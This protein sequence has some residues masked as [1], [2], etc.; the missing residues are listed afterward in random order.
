MK[1]SI[2]KCAVTWIVALVMGVTTA[3]AQNA[4][5]DGTYRGAVT[6]TQMGKNKGV[7]CVTFSPSLNVRGGKFEMRWNADNTFVGTVGPGGEVEANTQDVQLKAKISGDTVSGH[8]V[9]L[10]CSYDLATLKKVKS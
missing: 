9:S 8:S 3:T 2:H 5:F 6:G 1:H 7:P 10:Y 4:T